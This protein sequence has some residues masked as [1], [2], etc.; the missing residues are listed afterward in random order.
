MNDRCELCDKECFVVGHH[1]KGYD[2]PGD[3]WWIC[4][5]CNAKLKYKHDNIMNWEQARIYIKYNQEWIY[6]CCRNQPNVSADQLE[7]EAHLRQSL[8]SILIVNGYDFREP[9]F[10]EKY[11]ELLEPILSAVNPWKVKGV[12]R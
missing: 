5:S 2:H 3:L 9:I 7:A 6:L 1:W 10:L 4:T 11:T 12:A 8:T